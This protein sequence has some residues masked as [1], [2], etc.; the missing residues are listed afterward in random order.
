MKDEV[1]SIVTSDVNMMR[2]YEMDD[3]EYEGD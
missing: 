1:K 3:M 2:C